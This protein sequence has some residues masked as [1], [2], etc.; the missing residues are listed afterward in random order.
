MAIVPPGRKWIS[1]KPIR[2]WYSPGAF[3]IFAD[4]S[5]GQIPAGYEGQTARFQISRDGVT[6]H[7]YPIVGWRTGGHLVYAPAT[8]RLFNTATGEAHIFTWNDGAD[9]LRRH[10]LQG[11]FERI[12]PTTSRGRA[13]WKFV[14]VQP[15][16]VIP[17]D[18]G[19]EP[20][21]I[22]DAVAD[23]IFPEWPPRKYGNNG[24]V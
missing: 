17:T 16:G 24:G 19:S 11:N 3:V 1:V 7:Y 5:T 21:A 4:G 12:P 9:F 13:H 14:Y 8:N 23:H 18:A 15:V 20:G 2:C 6:Y 10:V 22:V